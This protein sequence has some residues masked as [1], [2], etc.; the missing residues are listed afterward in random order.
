VTLAPGGAEARL[1]VDGSDRG[2]SGLRLPA[3]NASVEIGS[4]G[5]RFLPGLLDEVRIY[6]RVLPPEEIAA[7]Y[8]RE[9]EIGK[10]LQQ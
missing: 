10:L 6:D 7:T 9:A 1:F 3:G 4:A 8:R 2:A 5:G